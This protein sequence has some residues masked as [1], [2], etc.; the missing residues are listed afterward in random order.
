MYR[1]R[2]IEP[3]GFIVALA[4]LIFSF[5]FI[6]FDTAQPSKS[7]VAAVLTAGLA[8]ITYVLLRCVILALRKP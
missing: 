1:N 7:F 6:T 5:F 8:W 4:T 2:I 3:I